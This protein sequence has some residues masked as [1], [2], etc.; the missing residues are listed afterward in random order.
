MNKESFDQFKNNMLKFSEDAGL[1]AEQFSELKAANDLVVRLARKQKRQLELMEEDRQKTNDEIKLIKLEL[2][3]AHEKIKA[4][5][6]EKLQ[7]KASVEMEPDA[8]ENDSPVH[9]TLDLEKLAND[10]DTKIAK[11]EEHE[12]FKYLKKMD[13]GL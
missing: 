3:K 9:D 5:E 13:M 8:I 12:A 11:K 1:L 7:S 4:L 10:I 2:R 6:K